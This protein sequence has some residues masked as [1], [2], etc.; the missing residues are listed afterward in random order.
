MSSKKCHTLIISNKIIYPISILGQHMEYKWKFIIR[1]CYNHTILS[2]VY[3][4]I[5]L[6]Y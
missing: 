6:A 5:I 1:T 4:H 3:L 2:D